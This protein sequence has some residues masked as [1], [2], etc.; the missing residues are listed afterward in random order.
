MRVRAQ[1]GPTW[2]CDGAWPACWRAPRQTPVHSADD[3]SC[4]RRSYNPARRDARCPSCDF[5]LC[6]ARRVRRLRRFGARRGR[7]ASGADDAAIH[8]APAVA[9][10][11]HP[12]GARP[13]RRSAAPLSRYASVALLAPLRQDCA[14]VAHLLA[15][16]LRAS[17]SDPSAAKNRCPSSNSCVSRGR[18]RR[19]QSAGSDSGS[20]RRHAR[21]SPR[22]G[23]G[24]IARRE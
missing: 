12:G 7:N 4:G 19:S 21:S 23:L 16:A 8:I 1:H 24:T 9:G 10:R 2:P 17:G 5:P 3:E 6:G 13:R 14:L 18:A 11:R 22:P 15:V 20:A